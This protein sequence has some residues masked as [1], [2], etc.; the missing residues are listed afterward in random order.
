MPPATSSIV[1]T[2]TRFMWRM[3][4]SASIQN[5]SEVAAAA[6]LGA[7]HVAVEALVVGL[8]RRE[9]REVV[10]ADERGGARLQRLEVER[11]RPPQRAT[12]LERRR[13]GPGEQR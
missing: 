1:P 8:G 9:G 2:S 3:N 10:R 4:S 11:V 13:C 7:E 6:P 12:G 5:S